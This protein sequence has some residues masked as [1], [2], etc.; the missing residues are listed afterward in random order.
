[1]T[2][3]S[4]TEFDNVLDKN[5]FQGYQKLKL[6][7]SLSHNSP[8]TL[9]RWPGFQSFP[10]NFF[11]IE[12]CMTYLNPTKTFKYITLLSCQIREILS[13]YRPTISF[14]EDHQLVQGWNPVTTI[15]IKIL[16]NEI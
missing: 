5:S 15:K 16:K 6:V 12:C 7:Y 11:K 4:K 8:Q 10:F 1:M 2:F 3:N 9:K 14:Y 13:I